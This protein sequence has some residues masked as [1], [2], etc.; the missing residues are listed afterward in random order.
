MA[1][2]PIRHVVMFRWN[3]TV[4][5]AHVG[6]LGARLDALPETIPEIRSYRHGADVGVN[7]GNYDYAVVGDFAS[8]GDYLVYRDHPAHRALI[9]ELIADRITDRAAVQFELDARWR[10]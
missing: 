5:E 1:T 4:D 6:V 7:E 2:S 8:L 9:A 10:A 3:D